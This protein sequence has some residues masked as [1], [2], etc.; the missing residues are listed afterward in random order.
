MLPAVIDSIDNVV[1]TE[2]LIVILID[3]VVCDFDSGIDVDWCA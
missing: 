3:L 1:S 2:V